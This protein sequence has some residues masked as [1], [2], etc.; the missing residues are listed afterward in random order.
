M[1]ALTKKLFREINHLRGQM[2]AIVVVIA[3]GIANFVAFRSVHASLSLTQSSFYNESRFADVFLTARRAPE[4]VAQRIA[5]VPGVALVQTRVSAE[6]ML[7]LPTVQEPASGVILSVPENDQPALNQ[8]YLRSGRWVTEGSESEVMISTAFA[9]ANGFEEGDQ[10]SAIINGRKRRLSIVARVISPEHI[11]EMPAGTMILDNKRY[12]TMWMSRSAL[13]AAYNMKGA[14][15]SATLMLENGADEK[16]VKEIIDHILKPYGTIGS[17]GRDE[18]LSNRFLSDDIAQVQGQAIIIP[19]IF[20]GVAIFLLNIALL[21]L[22]GTQR[23]SIA[24]LK[25]F[26]YSQSAIGLHYIG[27]ALV[28]VSAGSLIG[29]IGGQYLGEGITALYARFYR[30]P[31]LHFDVPDGV[32][33]GSI[34]LSA[35]AAVLGAVSAVRSVLK[36]PAAEAMRPQAPKSFKPGVLERI[37]LFRRLD[38][39][40][41]MI[42]R[43]IERRPVKTMLSIS[44]IALAT[45]ILVIGRSMFDMFD[46][47]MDSQF[48]SANRQDATVIFTNSR[49]ADVDNDVYHL[50]GVLRV[51]PFRMVPVDVSYKSKTK[52]LAIQSISEEQEL[53][54]VIDFDGKPVYIPESGLV[55]TKYLA[56]K[57]GLAIGDSLSVKLLEGDRR[58]FQVPLTGTANEMFGIQAYMNYKALSALLREQGSVSGSAILFDRNSYAE[59]SQEVKNTPAIASVMMRDAMI[60]SFDENYKENMDISTIYIVAFSMIIAFGVVYNSARIAL[61]ERAIELASLRV[62]GFTINE[63]TIVLLGEQVIILLMALP[64]GLI[65]GALG[66]MGL[67]ATYEN[68]LFRFPVIITERN[69]GLASLAICCVAI[70]TGVLLRRKLSKLDLIEVLKSRE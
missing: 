53:I 1:T 56:D 24:I 4:S 41:A 42:W 34:V 39:V 61:S 50:P 11:I 14:F 28:A 37:P 48:N 26:G 32:V 60:R 25:A 30:F 51:E 68:D 54:R 52:R 31:E 13:S 22:V 16:T 38:P 35:V 9:D 58:T 5:E 17:I 59:F 57:L 40:T 19:T 45:A 33:V 21:R 66:I 27:F 10:F 43:T 46:L 2:I 3:C 44:M 15:N 23:M 36:L 18:Q 20:L 8:L 64:I 67:P 29:F 55:L 7:D 47:I 70:A 12:G 63:I 65:L 6:V 49:S 69:L 62:L